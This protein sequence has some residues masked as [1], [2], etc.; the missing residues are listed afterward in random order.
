MRAQGALPCCLLQ[1]G[2]AG[3]CYQA[4]AD[5]MQI[6]LRAVVTVARFVGE[7]VTLLALY[8]T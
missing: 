5:V 1:A 6:Y 4:A 7:V 2:A 3:V 8:T